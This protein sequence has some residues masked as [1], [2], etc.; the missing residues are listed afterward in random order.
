MRGHRESKSDRLYKEEED[1]KSSSWLLHISLCHLHSMSWPSSADEM[2]MHM[3]PD[4]HFHFHH[5]E[6][7]LSAR[8]SLSFTYLCHHVSNLSL[9][10]FSSFQHTYL[11][12]ALI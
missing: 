4:R 2:L 11:G 8:L 12:L 9:P 10:L 3:S 7:L 1:L 6:H 5:S